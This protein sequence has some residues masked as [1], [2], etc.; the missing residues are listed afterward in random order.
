M[1]SE[2]VK[3]GYCTLC[4][5]RCGTLNTVDQGKLIRI[6]PDTSHP[7]GAAMCLKG[8]AAPELVYHPDRV[9]YPMRR[10][11]PKGASDPGWQS[12]TW[13]E[14]LDEIASRLSHVKAA[15]GAESVA[16]GVTT[17]SG[18]PMS[19]SIDWVERFIWMFGSPN[20][21]YATE[22][23]NW[24]KDYA[25]AFTFGCG[26]PTADYEHA[27]VI[28]LWGTNPAN[29]W[30][31]Q[32]DAIGRGRR[33]GA[34]LVVIDPRPTA[35]AKQANL[36]MGVRPGTDAA[37]AMGIAREMIETGHV[38]WRFMR[39]WTNA[40]L[41]VREDNGLLLRERDLDPR[42]ET[43]RY[44]AWTSS[45]QRPV[46][47]S[48]DADV[49]DDVA[50]EGVFEVTIAQPGGVTKNIRCATA[51]QHYRDAISAYTPEHVETLTGVSACAVREMAA[52]LRPGQRIAYHAWSGVGQHHNATQT[53][54]AIA[55]LYALT[56]A[57]DTRGSNRQ[58]RK[59][60]VNALS[61]YIAQMPAGQ[62]D[63]ALGLDERPLGPPANGWITARDL[64]RAIDE[65]EPY[66]IKAL[67]TFGTNLLVSQAESQ[68]AVQAL[69]SVDFHV[70][71]DLFE[72]PSSAYADIFL[73]ANTPWERDGLRAGFEINERALE[74][75]Q[76]RAAMV[77]PLGESRAD[78]RIV[79][80]LAVRLG[81]GDAFFGGDIEAGWDHM[82]APLG[83]DVATLRAH[84]EGIRVS[85]PQVEKGYAQTH[86][87]KPRGFDTETGRVELYSERL[88]RHGY[89]PL[90]SFAPRPERNAAFPLWL[91]SMKNGL[92][93]HSQHRGIASLRRRAPYPIAELSAELA[94]RREIADGDWMTIHTEA[95]TA[96]FRAR[97][98]PELLAD[99]VVAEYGWWQACDAVGLDAMPVA[100]ASNSNFSNLVSLAQLDP[101][102]GSSSLKSTPCDVSLDPSC[103]PRRRAWQGLRPFVVI[104][105][106]EE[107]SGVR[108]IDF[109]AQDGGLLPDYLPGQHVTVHVPTLGDG[110][111]TRAYSLVG[112][113]RVGDRRRYTIAVRHQ[114]GIG[115]DG[116]QFE[117]TM[118]GHVHGA[119]QP[120]DVVSLG[121]PGGTF[122][123]PSQSS[124]PVVMISGGIGITPFI[125]LI[126]TVAAEDQAPPLWLY[127]ANL[128][129]NTHAFRRRLEEL[130]ARMPSLHVVNAYDRPDDA[131]PAGAYQ[132]AGRMSP[133]HIDD[134][135]IR[136]RARFYLCGPK[137][138]MDAMIAGLQARG[139]PAFDIFHEVFRSPAR[140]PTDSFAAFDVRFAR[141]GKQARWT[142]A[143]GTLLTF[144]EKLGISMASGCRVGQCESCAV[145]L[146]K[147]QV[148]H[149]SGDGPDDPATCFACQA[150]PVED[151]VIDA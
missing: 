145:H 114:R 25:H 17:P 43:N 111:T 89:A 72:T 33:R 134:A 40:P 106:A 91:T 10:T 53:E 48:R 29:T 51:F 75:V 131:T 42:A 3:K 100:G 97:V 121:A 63:K 47:V 83:L 118:S 124:R 86:D 79:A 35:F 146:N 108:V 38:D 60:P 136:S 9:L 142:A 70:H 109:V 81:M 44:V 80:D 95:G 66:P 14:A 85:T 147:G 46:S 15:Y 102:S 133:D 50:L 137:P 98:V 55:T 36:W 77:E 28:I 54:R 93:C 30:L 120:G 20:I 58:Y 27:D 76:L 143:Q 103:D 6:Q 141:S 94:A 150:I 11:N 90:P 16:F 18:T 126:E 69:S 68:S 71:C 61:N 119:L 1:A 105:I 113:A 45:D 132:I 7:T 24:H 8:R 5:S 22:I 34:R 104:A 59:P 4:R 78:Y 128:D 88:L 115:A 19:D 73:P 74:H 23:C 82:L 64:F 56:G 148:R 49:Q 57:F 87:G 2:T 67:V 122:V 92:Y 31:A 125:T 139:V 123:L 110:G 37:L 65:G 101:I 62:R 99:V 112:P 13:D 52:M 107:A 116:V 135:L 21:C 151:L 138:M 12:I 41:L 96:R 117:G 129:A 39:D 127:Y 26:L 130:C 149:L 84:P 32:A 144:A 140:L